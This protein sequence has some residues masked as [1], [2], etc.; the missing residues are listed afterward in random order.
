MPREHCP[1]TTGIYGLHQPT[2][3][4]KAAAL[5]PLAHLQEWQEALLSAISLLVT[6]TCVFWRSRVVCQLVETTSKYCC[7]FTSP[8]LLHFSKGY[9]VWS[10]GTA[11]HEA[12]SRKCV[13][14]F[15]ARVVEN[16]SCHPR[17]SF[18]GRREDVLANPLE[19]C[20]H[21]TERWLNS[22]SCG[23]FS[24]IYISVS[25]MLARLSRSR[26][27]LLGYDQQ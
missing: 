20:I 6:R 14:L 26:C 8:V 24:A 13:V 16:V 23:L 7:F 10:A 18:A 1:G 3:R 19:V 22:R 12:S 15:S 17:A 25:F 11:I 2:N 21:R 5:V 4:H 27:I 9:T